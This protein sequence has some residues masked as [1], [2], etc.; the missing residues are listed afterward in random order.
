MIRAQIDWD[1]AESNGFPHAGFGTL[2]SC[3]FGLATTQEL[4]TTKSHTAL[5]TGPVEI[6]YL[7]ELGVGRGYLQGLV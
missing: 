3:F 5:A 4:N 6:I 2:V 7:R 1:G